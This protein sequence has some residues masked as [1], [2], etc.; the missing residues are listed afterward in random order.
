[1]TNSKFHFSLSL[2]VVAIFAVAMLASL[3]PDLYPEF[4]GDY[5][6]TGKLWNEKLNVYLGCS[7]PAEGPHGPTNHWGYRHFLFFL[8]GIVLFVLQAIR[9]VSFYNKNKAA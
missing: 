9:L 4:F 3:M 5:K 7:A 1:M 8:M 6:C 2:Q